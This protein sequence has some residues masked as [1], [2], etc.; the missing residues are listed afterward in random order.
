MELEQPNFCWFLSAKASQRVYPSILF[1]FTKAA[2]QSPTPVICSVLSPP[3]LVPLAISLHLPLSHWEDLPSFLFNSAYLSDS[4]FIKPTA[5]IPDSTDLSIL[6]IGN[7]TR[8]Q[9]LLRTGNL[10]E[11]VKMQKKYPCLEEAYFL[12]KWE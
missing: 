7:T 1:S 4:T 5:V 8:R 11:R 10:S 9:H 12:G 2:P 3:C 6:F